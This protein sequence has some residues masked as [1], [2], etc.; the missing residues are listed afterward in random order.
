MSGWGVKTNSMNRGLPLLQAVA[1][2]I[3]AQWLR[4]QGQ[5]EVTRTAGRQAL[6]GRGVDI[7]YLSSGGLKRVKVKADPYFGVDPRLV[8]DRSL[9]FYREDEKSFAFEAVANVATRE[10]G[11]ILDSDA[12]DL[13]YYYLV[14]EQTEDEVK[15]LASERDEV[16]FAE[17]RV[18]RD[19]LIVLPMRETRTWF[20]A[21]ADR[22]TPRPVLYGGGS[23][24]Y[25]LVPREELLSS[26]SGIRT[27][28]PIFSSL[29]L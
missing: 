27:V 25:R 18:C 15:A 24:W 4:E 21:N 9:S 29:R 19:Q 17:L 16:L 7:T 22:F 5:R 23:G 8:S 6:G 28:G 11:W 20:E 14:I 10:L 12:D 26:I 13:Y 3:V 1:E 2:R